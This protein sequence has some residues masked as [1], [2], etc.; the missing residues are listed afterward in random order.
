[1]D[2]VIAE[3]VSLSPNL[4]SYALGQSMGKQTAIPRTLTLTEMVSFSFTMGTTPMEISS[5][6]VL[7]AFRYRVRCYQGFGMCYMSAE[8][9]ED[10][11]IRLRCLPLLA[12]PAQW[13]DLGSQRGH[14]IT[15]LVALDL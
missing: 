7:T 13:V 10:R 9:K 11:H 2:A 6:N 3:S 14:R 4:I 5:L 8:C 12:V 15:R 1:M